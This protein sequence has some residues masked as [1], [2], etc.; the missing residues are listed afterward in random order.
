MAFDAQPRLNGELL[1]L[2]PLV[3]GDWDGLLA[4][5]ADPLTWEQH[6]DKTRSTPEGFRRYFDDAVASGGALTICDAADGR[7]IG[8]SRYHDW[9]GDD[10]DVEIG[11]TFLAR[12]YWGGRYNAELKRLMVDHALTSL[13]AVVFLV[14]P[15]NMRSQRAVE[16]IGGVRVGLR[17]DERGTNVV[18]RIDRR[19]WAQ[20]SAAGA[21]SA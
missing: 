6:P 4:A 20:V 9:G 2:R 1:E 5:A 10:G 16:K 19:R 3:A 15:G 14:D 8:S 18:F 13:D 17:T 11:W 7:I 21:P 12:P